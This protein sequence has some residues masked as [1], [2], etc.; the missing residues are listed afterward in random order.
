ML[1]F[2]YY[3]GS[4]MKLIFKIYLFAGDVFTEDVSK[5]KRSRGSRNHHNRVNSNTRSD[6]T[7]SRER[8]H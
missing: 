7:N 3:L 5:Y 8:I 1:I 6:L 4:Y 2:T